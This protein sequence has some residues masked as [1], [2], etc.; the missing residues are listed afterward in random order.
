[1]HYN[2]H[3]PTIQHYCTDNKHCRKTIFNDTHFWW[4]NY[5][6]VRNTFS[7]MKEQRINSFLNLEINVHMTIFE[8]KTK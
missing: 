1:M 2:M 7:V 8:G 4:I 3:S 6:L 5:A